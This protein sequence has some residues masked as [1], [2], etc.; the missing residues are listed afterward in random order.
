FGADESHPRSLVVA[1]LDPEGRAMMVGELLPQYIWGPDDEL[2]AATAFCIVEDTT[3][4]VLYCSG[5]MPQPAF[6]AAE[7]ASHA[8]FG[9]ATWKWEG[10]TFT[11]RA[12]SQFLRA[13]FATPD[14]IVL[15]TQ[16]QSHQI[17][18]AKEFTAGYI[19]VA[20]LALLLATWFTLRQSRNILEPVAKLAARAREISRNEFGARLAIKRDDEFGELGTAFDQMSDKLGRQ[21]ASLTALSEIDRLILS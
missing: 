5:P 9:A 3:L 20:L 14:W 13:A 11:S 18:R 6:A 7:A 1:P 12:W 16:P 4:R 2:P 17:E 21:I 10:E 8:S 19:P 15:A